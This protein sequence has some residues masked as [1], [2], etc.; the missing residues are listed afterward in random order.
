M[1]QPNQKNQGFTLLEFIVALVVLA[2]GSVLLL[3][4]VTPTAGSADPMIQAQA[5]A[6]ASAYM[7]EILLRDFDGDCS[8]N[9]GQWSGIQCYNGLTEPPT[10][11][12][13]NAI[14][15]LGAYQVNVSIGSGNPATITVA[16]SHASGRG[17][18]TLQSARGDY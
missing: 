4:F 15:A 5:R 13:D 16:V 3:S 1:P 12:F 10:D 6:I 2:L 9:R 8:G 17:G 11:Q 7:D 18:F 14:A